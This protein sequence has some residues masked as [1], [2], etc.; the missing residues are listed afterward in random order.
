MR[1]PVSS[2][3]VTPV[4][5]PQLQPSDDP[6]Q[7]TL[8]LV[9]QDISR[10]LMNIQLPANPLVPLMTIPAGALGTPNPLGGTLGSVLVVPVAAAAMKYSSR[11]RAK[12][13]NKGKKS[14][15][16]KKSRS[17]SSSSSSTSSVE[18]PPPKP[19]ADQ[20]FLLCLYFPLSID[21]AWVIHSF[22]TDIFITDKR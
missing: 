12:K 16:T 5:Q 20:V 1:F 11:K 18:V 6:V 2:T 7:L 19:S 10:P 3:Q 8:T 13:Q 22:Q 21:T 15:K 14:K 9:N 4:L 17:R